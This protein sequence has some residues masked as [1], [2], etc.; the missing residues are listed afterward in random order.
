[1]SAPVPHEFLYLCYGYVQLP[2]QQDS[3]QDG[4]LVIA[5]TAVAVF[6]V[7]GG[8]LKQADLVVPQQSFL[9]MPWRAANWPMVR[10]LLFSSMITIDSFP[11]VI[12]CVAG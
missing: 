1:M 8:G 12:P 7:D 9:L 4:T 5:V 3:F 2:Q 11:D 6:G 10:S